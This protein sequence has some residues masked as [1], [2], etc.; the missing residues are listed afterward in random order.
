MEEREGL[1][2]SLWTGGSSGAPI[3]ATDSPP[4]PQA[5]QSTCPVL[6][7][8]RRSPLGELVCS[9]GASLDL[10]FLFRNASRQAALGFEPGGSR[11]D[12]QVPTTTPKA[13]QCLLLG[14]PFRFGASLTF[15]PKA[16]K[17]YSTRT[18][19]RTTRGYAH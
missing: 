3:A 1:P 5:V 18:H 6:G 7:A 2:Y 15:R 16:L 19:A 17:S 14:N 13:L 12:R 4:S 9:R 10:A 8:S 11:S